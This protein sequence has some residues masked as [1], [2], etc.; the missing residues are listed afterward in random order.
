MYGRIVKGIGGFYFVSRIPESYEIFMCNARGRL[1]TCNNT[2]YV[3]DFVDFEKNDGHDEYVITKLYDRK[4]YLVR[5]PV[6]NIDMIVIVIAS[7]DPRPNYL[8]ID[9]MCVA[10]AANGIDVAICVNKACMGGESELL[11]L[12]EIYEPLY[13]Y[14]ETDMLENKGINQLYDIISGKSV[15][16]AGASGVGKSTITNNIINLS[17][18]KYNYN[19]FAIEHMKTGDLS[20]KTKRGKHTTRHAELFILDDDTMIF[21]TP[22]FTS[23]DP[24][25]IDIYNI[26]DMFIDFKILIKEN[27]RFKDCLHVKEPG[28]AVKKA[29]KEGIISEERYK[30]YLAILEFERKLANKW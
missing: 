11:K 14:V 12:R 7:I 22:G 21:D 16:L 19:D 25:E 27:C 26:K 15:A 30:S 18:N 5:P 8:A 10:S 17:K 20:S 4:N 1:K 2:L 3:G 9:K 28:C 13:P 24:P 29:L 23:I 6:S